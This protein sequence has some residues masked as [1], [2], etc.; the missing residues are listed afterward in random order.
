VR[1]LEEVRMAR[2]AVDTPT[3]GSIRQPSWGRLGLEIV[4]DLV[5]WLA[6]FSILQLVGTGAIQKVTGSSLVVELFL[7]LILFFA[8][9]VVVRVAF[10]L[11]TRR[12]PR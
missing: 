10:I 7:V 1:V 2:A 4:I 8:V 12:A 9:T 5:G 3:D 11:V 6:V